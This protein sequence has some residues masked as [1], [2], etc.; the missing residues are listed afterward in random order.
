VQRSSV[1]LNAIL[2][3]RG[4]EYGDFTEQAKISQ[5][6]RDAASAGQNFYRMEPFQ[7]EALSMILHKIS[8]IVNG[9]TRNVDSW[10]DIAGYA[11]LVA[12]RLQK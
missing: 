1:D 10:A 2:E 7:T 12:N 3:E 6:L 4:S 8:R 5:A 11:T 9:N